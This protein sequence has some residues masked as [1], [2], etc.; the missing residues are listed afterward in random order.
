VHTGALSPE[1]AAQ[2]RIVVLT[3]TPLAQVC[4]GPIMVFS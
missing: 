4:H 1:F 3:N 2:F